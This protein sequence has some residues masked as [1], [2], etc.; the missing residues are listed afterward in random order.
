MFYANLFR[1]NRRKN[2]QNVNKI[3]HLKSLKA[4][5]NKFK[6]NETMKRNLFDF[7]SERVFVISK[8]MQKRKQSIFS[9]NNA[10]QSTHTSVCTIHYTNKNKQRVER[11][12]FG[13]F[14]CCDCC[15]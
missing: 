7:H 5:K 12:L 13:I 8:G 2:G 11:N 6:S 4:I 9:D 3:Q 10:K 1:I 15:W 14:C